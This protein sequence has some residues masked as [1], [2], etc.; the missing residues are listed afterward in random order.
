MYS[1]KDFTK[2]NMQKNTDN[3]NIKAKYRCHK[4]LLIWYWLSTLEYR[5]SSYI[6]YWYQ[7]LQIQTNRVFRAEDQ[8]V[9]ICPVYS[10]VFSESQAPVLLL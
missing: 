4:K 6:D 9:V 3:T 7:T 2:L 5:Y 1:E 10:L 8:V